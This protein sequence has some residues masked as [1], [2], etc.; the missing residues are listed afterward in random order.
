MK[1]QRIDPAKLRLSRQPDSIQLGPSKVLS[2]SWS[3]GNSDSGKN[4]PPQQQEERP[5][6]PTNRLSV[7]KSLL[8]VT[9]LLLPDSYRF[10]IPYEIPNKVNCTGGSEILAVRHHLTSAINYVL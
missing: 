4:T 6:A 1:T 5:N 2:G 8:S 7:S 10:F 3:M 9:S